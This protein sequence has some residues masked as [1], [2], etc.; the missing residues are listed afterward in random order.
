MEI[1]DHGPSETLE[2]QRIRSQIEA[3]LL[4]RTAASTH[5]RYG[6]AKQQAIGVM[7]GLVVE[8]GPG[9]G[10][11]MRYY[12]PG[13]R[14]IGIEPNPAMHGRLQRAADLA[15]V[16]LEIRNLGGEH[17][18]IAD[19]SADGVVGTRVLCGVVD[20]SGV[21]DEV[22]RVLKP[23]GAYFF[24]EH[25]VAPERTNTRRA[26]RLLKRPHR[27]M[28]NGCEVDRDTAASIE[29]AGFAT[30]EMEEVDEGVAAGH[31]R[32]HIVGTATK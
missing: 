19:G 29:M 17:L 8:L 9:T 18:D 28:F 25:V 20:L 1:E 15:G 7:S 11:N 6:E 4:D 5:Q 3:R 26:Q 24:L 21:L 23:G 31:V 27:W 13:T 30:V 16:D 32:H 10:L 14:V 22:L 2:K 12:S